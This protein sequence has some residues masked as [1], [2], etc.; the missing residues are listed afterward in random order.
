MAAGRYQQRSDGSRPPRR[1][2][3]LVIAAL[4]ILALAG[5]SIHRF[6]SSRRR[7]DNLPVQPTSDAGLAV[8]AVEGVLFEE[9]CTRKDLT[10]H[11]EGGVI[12]LAFLLD[13][14]AKTDLL[15]DRLG[16][17]L[18]SLG[19]RMGPPSQR[20]Q[21]ETETITVGASPIP[22]GVNGSLTIVL[23]KRHLPYQ[24]PLAA[25]ERSAKPRL[26]IVID[27]LG[28]TLEAA[29][30]ATSLPAAITVAVMPRQPASKESARLALRR[31]KEVLLHLPMEPLEFPD[32]DPGP[33]ALLAGMTR[34]EMAQVLKDD[35]LTVPGAVGINNHMGSRLTANAAAMDLLLRMVGRSRLFFL[36]SR[37]TSNSLAYQTARSLGL[38]AV[39]RDIFLD[40]LDEPA[41]IQIQVD[42]LIKLALSQGEAVGIG[43]PRDNTFAVLIQS[44]DRIR[45]AGI[46]IVPLSRLAR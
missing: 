45:K 44:M 15:L 19:W 29:E 22:R 8:L 12:S 7:A 32:K 25:R 33:G 36:D 9:G 4:L 10:R 38:R 37:T 6:Q 46:D 20:G 31:G 2:A 43:H 11:D 34:Q 26:A 42:E 16:K 41:A 39:R 5:L 21:G 1:A 24:V 30:K 40:N 18:S 28:L 35:L 3:F 27:D 13:P 23:A 14:A 17:A